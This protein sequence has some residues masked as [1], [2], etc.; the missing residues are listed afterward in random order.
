M[1]A[2]TGAI[3]VF[4]RLRS[5]ETPWN[6]PAVRAMFAAGERGGAA[7]C[8]AFVRE[9]AAELP[10]L[11]THRA[12]CVAISCGA[13]VEHGADPGIGGLA[14]VDRIRQ[15]RPPFDKNAMRMFDQAAMAHLCRSMP[16]RI[17]VRARGELDP[18]AA[19]WTTTVLDL[20]DDLHLLVLAPEHTRGWRVR[21]EAISTCAH[22]FTLLQA[23][24]IPPLP[25]EP[26]DPKVLATAT[27]EQPMGEVV[28]DHQRF[29]FDDW[30]ALETPTRLASGLGGFVPV[31]LSPARIRRLPDGRS[32]LLLGKPQLGGRSWDSG[33][34]ANIHDA[35]RSRVEIVETLSPDAVRAEL[36][37]ILDARATLQLAMRSLDGEQQL[38]VDEQPSKSRPWWSRW[39]GGSR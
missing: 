9:L 12:S 1:S 38:S 2:A 33:F 36:E 22:L 24:V 28:T 21:L 10:N 19:Y 14:I 17:A 27:G 15:V 23:A 32:V 20:V 7:A 31:D 26:I 29:R 16:L 37:A 30:T 18:D 4:R 34:F 11:D 25:G 3:E 6:D 13:L 5:G 35:L 8:D 39:F